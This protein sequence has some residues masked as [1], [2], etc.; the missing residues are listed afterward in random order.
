MVQRRTVRHELRSETK[1]PLDHV[2]AVRQIDVRKQALAGNPERTRSRPTRLR[3]QYTGHGQML[4]R[5]LA[6]RIGVSLI[7]AAADATPG[8]V[9][10]RA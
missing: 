10:A 7:P 1:Q 8:S 5:A 9:A 3:V 2:R 6:V 4:R